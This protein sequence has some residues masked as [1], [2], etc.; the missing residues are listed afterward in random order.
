[1]S[2]GIESIATC[3]PET[4]V[5][6]E[7]FRYLEPVL[8]RQGMSFEDFPRERRRETRRDAI[9]Y[10]L[11]GAARRAL[12]AAGLAPQD[13]DLIL[14]ETIGGRFV[15]PGVASGVHHELGIREGV[16][17]WNM[18]EVCA[19]FTDACHLASA[20]MRS[21][22][23]RYRRVLVMAAV[24]WNC[25]EWGADV[26]DPGIALIGDGA[27]AAVI[28][29]QNLRCE[30]LAYENRTDGEIYPWLI[31]AQHE[32]ANPTL[33]GSAAAPQN[34]AI[35]VFK[36]EF[37]PWFMR[38]GAG[39]SSRLI[40]PLLERAGIAPGDVHHIVTHQLMRVAVAAWPAS[41]E[42]SHGIPASRWHHTF[43]QYGNVAAADTW[44]TLS[45]LVSA[46]T[47][48]A[49]AN[50]VMFSPAGAGHNSAMALRWLR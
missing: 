25:G 5:P 50:I 36:P 37:G 8:A 18:Q 21:E 32:A 20:M 34:C 46:R 7:E 30:I 1:M 28:S 44:I 47:F 33:C 27:V 16:P 26:T 31:V 45:D 15:L 49:G 38:T 41:L 9:E 43:D 40:P 14:C 35:M 22:P 13:I 39:I 11:T 10:L 6:L 3:M 17:A 29:R 19:S 12:D 48:R 42:A 24:A 2:I 23:E 4:V